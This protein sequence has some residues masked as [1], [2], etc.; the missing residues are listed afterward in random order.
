MQ[1]AAG[2]T[3]FPDFSFSNRVRPLL[4]PVRLGTAERRLSRP[5]AGLRHDGSECHVAFRETA[6]LL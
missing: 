1:I 4:D 5:T 3:A 6:L 2:A